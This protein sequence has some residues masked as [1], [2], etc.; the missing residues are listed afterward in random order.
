MTVHIRVGD[1]GIMLCGLTKPE[2]LPLDAVLPVEPQEF[3][4]SR[5]GS[6]IAAPVLWQ[7]VP[8]GEGCG[9]CMKIWK[10]RQEPWI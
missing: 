1:S 3:R 10:T 2:L 6:V 5:G 7:F 8:Q 9:K 4:E